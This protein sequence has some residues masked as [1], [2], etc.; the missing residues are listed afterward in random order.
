MTDRYAVIGTPIG[1]SKSP[2]LHTEFAA[3]MG[4]D[5]VYVAIE[6]AEG[7]FAAAVDGFRAAGGRGLNVTTPFKLDAVAYATAPAARVAAAGA[8][9]ALRFEGAAVLAENFDGVGLVRDIVANLGC[10]IAGR[11]VLVLGAGGAARGALGPIAA[12]GPARLVVASRDG[13]GLPGVE[14]A[15]LD[16]VVGAFDVVVNATSASLRGERPAVGDGVFAAGGL[17]YDMVYGRGL[18]PFLRQGREAGAR[19]AEGVGMLVEQA[20]EAF[21]WWRGVRPPTRAAIV[22]LSSSLE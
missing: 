20:A 16:G 15:T 12:E 5:M 18:T 13:A 21:V 10:V 11:R 8:A 14:S 7:G 4:Q 6:A 3:E 19:V 1:H 22:R 17:A 9:N 2:A